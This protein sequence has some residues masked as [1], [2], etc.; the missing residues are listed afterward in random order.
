MT[1]QLTEYLESIRKSAL[2]ERDAAPAELDELE[3]HIEDT[4]LELEE[5]G[6][7]EEEAIETCLGKM[8]ST[9]LIAKQIY[10]AHAQ[11]SWKQVLL[12]CLPHFVFGLVFM[13]NWWQHAGG[14]TAVLLITLGII[15][16]AWWHGNKPNWIFSWLGFTMIPVLAVGILLLYLPKVWSL[17][18]LVLYFPLAMW[19]LFRVVVETTKRDWLFGSIALI[20]V[21]VAA[22]W[23]L[24]LCPG[25][26]ITSETVDRVYEMGPWIGLSFLVLALVIGVFIRLRQ[27]WLRGMLMAASSVLTGTLIYY[28]TTGNLT[29]GTFFGL[30]LVMWGVLLFPAI[31]DR[32]MRR[33]PRTIWK[34]TR[35][36]RSLRAPA[37]PDDGERSR[38]FRNT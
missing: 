36:I 14:L 12:A 34:D 30:M 15:T 9:K 19:W 24:A 20:P 18:T 17:I 31:I 28:H 22:G 8:G 27:R 11:G 37:E 25:F 23:Y 21:P 33:G 13:L 4:L 2:L 35:Y 3:A 1:P 7:S 29:T 16:Y 32:W 26:N 10:E 38:P 6:L 5:S